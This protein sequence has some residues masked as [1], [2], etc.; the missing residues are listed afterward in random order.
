MQLIL[1]LSVHHQDLWDELGTYLKRCCGKQ[2]G[3]WISFFIAMSAGETDLAA[4]QLDDEEK[5]VKG[6]KTRRQKFIKVRMVASQAVA[7]EFIVTGC[8]LVVSSLCYFLNEAGF[9]AYKQLIPLQTG[10]SSDCKQSN[11]SAI[12]ELACI[13][14]GD[15]AVG[16]IYTGKAGGCTI[17]ENMATYNHLVTFTDTSD[18]TR[19]L[20][21]VPLDCTDIRIENATTV[22]QS[23]DVD[24]SQPPDHSYRI[25]DEGD[26]VSDDCDPGP[27]QVRSNMLSFVTVFTA[28]VL[29]VV[30][31]KAILTRK[32]RKMVAENEQA[33]RG[34]LVLDPKEL[35]RVEA[36]V[37]RENER[38]DQAEKLEEE[39]TPLRKMQ[40]GVRAIQFAHRLGK[41]AEQKE[42]LDD[43]MVEVAE[44]V[45]Q[46]WLDVRLHYIAVVMGYLTGA[47]LWMGWVVKASG[48][49]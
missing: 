9:V 4:N 31:S 23:L 46:H 32:M 43:V 25:C 22:M 1:R 12:Q 38:Q 42:S 18:L 35:K 30:L 17:P 13:C 21:M 26:P 27:D 3:K 39:L 8:F 28:Q 40:R 41:S 19:P 33:R 10:V 44:A 15:G 24:W 45:A 48:R 29:A 49:S 5:G 7:S 34:L 11:G 2:R 16:G 36:F 14:D 47:F 37:A 6:S 20:C